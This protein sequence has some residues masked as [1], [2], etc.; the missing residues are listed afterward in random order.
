[1]GAFL[2]NICYFCS[3]N[4]L[5]VHIITQSKDLPVLD[6]TDFFHSP[7]LFRL[8][9]QTAGVWPYMVV[10]EDAQ[11]QVKGHLLAELCRRG[12]LIPPYLF[13]FGRIIGEGVYGEGVDKA[14]LF[15]QMLTALTRF[16]HRKLCLYVEV[17][18]L[19]TKMFGYRSLRQNGFF[20]VRWMQI[21]NSLHSKS[22]RERLSDRTA[23]HLLRSERAGVVVRE[24]QTAAEVSAYYRVLHAY[25]C[26]K[27]HRFIPKEEFFQQLLHSPRARM[28]ITYYKQRVVGGATIVVSG[29]DGYLW[30]VVA[31][32]KRYPSARPLAATVWRVLQ[33]CHAHNL[34]H[35][36]FLN[37]GL[38][39]RR[40][41]YRDFILG[42]GGKP[43]SSYRWFHFT[44]G[45]FNR[46]LS[47]FYRE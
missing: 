12:S 45:W 9:E 14:V 21:H 10:A 28:L 1:M 33:V 20:P 8:M 23:H 25:Y 7:E 11:G 41:P 13:T 40:S 35:V 22:P 44:I 42:F 47:W 4:T 36:F 38:P 37:V 3:M 5:R 18:D 26:T 31:Q 46:L 2:E 24:A 16:L 43:V 27:L 6:G 17:S 15:D 34:R 39:F 32:G 30:Y 29:D 19:S